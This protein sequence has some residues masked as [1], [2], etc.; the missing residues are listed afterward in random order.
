MEAMT[1]M[2]MAA[3]QARF[4]GLTARKSNVEYQG[5]QIN[6]QRTALANESSNLYNQML[7]LEVPTPPSTNDFYETTY[8]MED[9]ANGLSSDYTITNIQ[10]ATDGSNTYR[11]TLST[12]I[13][14]SQ[15][16]PSSY[17]FTPSEVKN[18]DGSVL[19]GNYTFDQVASATIKLSENETNAGTIKY[20]KDDTNPLN[21]EGTVAITPWQI[22]KVP[23]DSSKI[24]GFA[25]CQEDLAAENEGDEE[26]YFYQD[27]K[28]KNHFFTATQ[29]EN[30]LNSSNTNKIFNSYN[31]STYY[32]EQTTDVDVT[33]E[34]TESD[35]ISSITVLN[36]DGIN[37]GAP[38]YLKGQTYSVSTTR[39]I[40]QDKYDEAMNDYK[41]NKDLYEKSISDINAK[42]EQIQKKDQQL[43][44]RLQQLNTEQNAIATEMESVT[45]VIDDNVE[46][47]FKVFA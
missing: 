25:T 40:N 45:K 39:A 36:G 34:K 18:A 46:K 37:E 43:E 1:V 11:A 35:R 19:G 4:L 30:M 20:N 23:G 24:T 27:S 21:D 44:L 14:H 13:E 28:G 47:T 31:S 12:K 10:K 38:S 9:S 3:S 41:Y 22:Y 29:L 8:V 33:V 5:Q 7:E 17:T 6:Q 32:T 42:T 15:S 26:Y 2:G 16:I